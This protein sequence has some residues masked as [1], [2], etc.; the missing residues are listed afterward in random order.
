MASGP[1][2]ARQVYRLSGK[3]WAGNTIPAYRRSWCGGS[4]DPAVVRE[5]FMKELPELLKALLRPEAYPDPTRT[6]EL[7]QTQI[8]Y[9]F[10]TQDYVYKIKKPIRLAYL[11]YSTLEKR[12]F[13]C[14]KE[15]ELNRR[16]CPEIYLGVVPV[17]RNGG[18]RIA[19]RGSKIEYAVKMVR[20]PQEAM[21]DVLLVKNRVSRGM[22]SSVAEKLAEFH[23]RANTSQSISAFGSLVAITRNMEENFSGA[24]A[25]IGKTLSRT[26]YQRIKVWT[27]KWLKSNATLFDRRVTA[28]RIRDCHGDLHAANVC[29]CRGICIYD[30]IEFNERF[31]YCDV[32]SEIAFLAMDLDYY[33]H[34]E[35]S[36]SFAQAYAEMSQD[37]ELPGLLDFY[38]CYRAYVRGKVHS[39]EMD[40]PFVPQEEKDKSR[41]AARSY[42]ELAE[43]Y[44]SR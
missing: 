14:L 34:P 29:F 36:Q 11:D 2:V 17:T 44:I 12:V 16:L 13:Y 10:L 23:R 42:F 38:K 7:V 15:V 40:D 33:G 28:G 27:E 31:R 20:L 30:C 9:V 41:A 32:A 22:M 25:Y 3:P 21:L 6:V 43:S 18:I 19:G 8:S 5:D 37:Q 1:D 26:Q 24:E 4:A 35:L 39:L